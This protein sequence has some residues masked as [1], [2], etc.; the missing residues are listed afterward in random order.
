MLHWLGVRKIHRLVSM[1]NMKYDAITGGGIEVGER[2]K[3][4]DDL[5]PA[6]ARVE[7]DAKKAAG[8]FTDGEVP[9]ADAARARPRAAACDESA[10]RRIAPP[11]AGACCRD[12]PRDARALRATSL[13]AVRRAGDSRHFRIDRARLDARRRARRRRHARALSRRSRS[14]ITAAGGTSRRAASTARPSSTRSSPA[15]AAAT[16]ARAHRPRRGQ[17]AARRRRGPRLA[18]R[19]ARDRP[20]R[21]RAPKAWRG[22]LPR[23]HGRALLVDARRSAARR[24]RRRWPRSTQRTLARRVPGQRRQSA[25]RPRRLARRCCGACGARAARDGRRA[26]F[27]ALTRLGA[28]CIDTLARGAR[29]TGRARRA[30]S[31]RCST[32]FGGIWLERPARCDGVPLGDAWRA[33]A[34][35]RRRASTR[36]WVPFHK[37][38]QWLAYSLLEPF[39]WAGVAVHRAAT[40]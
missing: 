32:C 14:R 40:R 26:S 25:G 4:P 36:G 21:S 31:A 30:S 7:M 12:A 10:R 39:E 5:I 18:L 33:S 24:C 2:V 22:E 23:V 9:D 17:R 6:D 16:G 20:A 37:L 35:R 19:R 27:G 28:R 15:A 38:S 1:S 13:A 11:A 3:I 29:S 8:Y 34:R